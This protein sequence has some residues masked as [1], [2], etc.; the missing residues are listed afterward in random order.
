MPKIYKVSTEEERGIGREDS[1]I[2]LKPHFG[3]TAQKMIS[4]IFSRS[5]VLRKVALRTQ[6]KEE[7]E[8][9]VEFERAKLSLKVRSD[10]HG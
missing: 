7:D 5:A 10:L 9:K 3:F 1:E 6:E 8:K 2:R 4:I